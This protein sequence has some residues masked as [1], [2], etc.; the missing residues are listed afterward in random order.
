MDNGQVEIDVVDTSTALQIGGRAGRFGTQFE[1]GE[2]TTFRR[3]DLQL[4]TD[5]ITRSVDS[6]KV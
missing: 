6:I 2:V 1:H 5:I 3:K 4:L